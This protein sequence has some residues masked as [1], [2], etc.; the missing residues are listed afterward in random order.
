L[1]RWQRC[2]A[3]S[4]AGS[5]AGVGVV[6]GM[7][8]RVQ[9]AVLAGLTDCGEVHGALAGLAE[10]A[11]IVGQPREQRPPQPKDVTHAFVV[12]AVAHFG[13]CRVS[14]VFRV[15]RGI[16]GREPLA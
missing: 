8:P 10:E 1:C 9:R 12:G 6:T 14:G 16:Q 3:G 15:H 11:F 4:G 13:P 2:S 5:G 7:W